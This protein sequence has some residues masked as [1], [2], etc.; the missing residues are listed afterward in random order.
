MRVLATLKTVWVAIC[1]IDD[2]VNLTAWVNKAV[3]EENQSAD[4][5]EKQV[6]HCR[7]GV[8]RCANA[9]SIAVTGTD[10]IPKHRQ[11]QL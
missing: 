2:D 7:P 9:E 10:V 5:I 11:S 4:D 6:G 1:L 3:W 8:D